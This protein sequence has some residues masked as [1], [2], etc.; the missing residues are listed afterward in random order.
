MP[1]LQ[2]INAGGM[3]VVTG[4]K[5]RAEL[6]GARV[7]VEKWIPD[8]MRWSVVTHTGERL[9]VKTECL[10]ASEEGFVPQH[11]VGEMLSGD[12]TTVRAWLDSG[13]DIDS[14]TPDGG[15]AT[16]LM[17]ACS[18]GLGDCAAELLARGADVNA[19]DDDGAT[20]LIC[21]LAHPPLV[22]LLLEAGGLSHLRWA[23]KERAKDGR[24]CGSALENAVHAGHNA[25]A[26]LLRAHDEAT[27]DGDGSEPGRDVFEKERE[28]LMRVCAAKLLTDQV[29]MGDFMD[30]ERDRWM[31]RLVT[32]AFADPRDAAA[33]SR[34]FSKHGDEGRLRLDLWIRVAET[35]ANT[36]AAHPRF[37]EI[38]MEVSDAMPGL[39]QSL[40][41]MANNEMG[42]VPGHSIPG[43]TPDFSR[44]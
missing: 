43:V 34:R 41:M 16:L 8:R 29:K 11:L 21:A 5:S 20:P 44:E 31:G 9:G 33:L 10:V 30:V 42:V 40:H 39:M 37:R 3:A 28:I 7:A 2:E 36:L 35:M 6:N 23:G 17:C 32:N 19:R 13:G 27:R 12:P 24:V 14:P 25:S 1:S 15:G 4:L 22:T 18:H 26:D 38:T